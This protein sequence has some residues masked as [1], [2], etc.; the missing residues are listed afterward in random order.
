M[1][2]KIEL[3]LEL[4]KVVMWLWLSKSCGEKK[5]DGRMISGELGL[6]ILPDD[7]MDEYES[8]DIFKE[9]TRLKVVEEVKGRRC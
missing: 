7:R 9:D 5:A 4:V 3:G 6:Q 1:F 2:C 8:E